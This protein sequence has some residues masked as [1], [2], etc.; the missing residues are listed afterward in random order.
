MQ[1]PGDSGAGPQ[2]EPEVKMIHGV[3]TFVNISACQP[4][5][6]SNLNRIVEHTTAEDSVAVTDVVYNVLINSNAMMHIPGTYDTYKCNDCNI[7]L[8]GY[9]R[10]DPH[11]VEHVQSGE[12][13][14]R[15]IKAK[16]RGREQELLIIQGRLRFQN[17][18]LPFPEFMWYS[19]HGYVTIH[20]TKYCIICS[21]PHGKD[22]Y[23]ACVAMGQ[24]LKTTLKHLKLDVS[25]DDTL[26]FTARGPETD[27]AL[28]IDSVLA[29][30]P[31][32]FS[33][34]GESA[35]MVHV[36][37]TVDSHTCFQCKLRVK[38][39]VQ[40][41]T[42]LGEHVYHI[43]KLGRDCPYIANRFKNLQHELGFIIGMINGL[44]LDD[45][46]YDVRFVSAV[47]KS[48]FA[49]GTVNWGRVVSLL[50]FGAALSHH[51]KDK[52][53]E[54]CMELVGEEISVYLLT[55][56]RDWLIK[57]NSW[58]GFVEFFREAD[59][60]SML[61]NVLLTIAGF[62]GIGAILTLLIM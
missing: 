15:Y 11:L 32:D 25:I 13:Q 35:N 40:N 23:M 21:R 44:S 42:L 20:G 14:C 57:N 47:A 52:G 31:R 30:F 54:N 26:L 27:S 29:H 2:P 36:P 7:V 18:F 3:P 50:A 53:N 43:H 37:Y 46:G 58:D 45:S 41:D 16:F 38:N 60:E 48:L 34:L 6:A 4:F 33:V 24:R 59:R 49:D 10:G 1:K 51:L 17:G 19:K 61:A 56:Q 8:S 5:V 12:G 62:A 55:D 9:K 28:E 39:F 22:H